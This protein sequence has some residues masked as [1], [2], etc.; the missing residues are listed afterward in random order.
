MT[1]CFFIR[2]AK[3]DQ[4]A[5]MLRLIWVFA[6]CTGHFVGFVVEFFKIYFLHFSSKRIISNIS[7]FFFFMLSCLHLYIFQIIRDYHMGFWLLQTILTQNPIISPRALAQGL[8]MVMDWYLGQ[9]PKPHVLICLSH[10]SNLLSF[11]C[12]EEYPSVFTTKQRKL[13]MKTSCNTIQLTSC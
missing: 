11:I 6:A 7:S 2:T 13:A 3:T 1:Q 12:L 8:I 4:T 9:W 5:R 10:Y